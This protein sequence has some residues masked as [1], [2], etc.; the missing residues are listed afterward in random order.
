MNIIWLTKLTDSDSFRITQIMMSEALHKQGNEVT[1][2]LARDFSEKKD[3]QKG[4]LYL[5]T[6]NA[7]VLSGIVYGMI[8]FWYFPF[9]A[10]KKKADIVIVGGD[11]IWSPFLFSLKLWGIPV[12]FDIRSL[13]TDTER[14]LVRD[15]SFYLSR[16]LVDGLTTITPELAEIL[17]KQYHLQAKK[18][19]VWSSGFSKNQFKGIEPKQNDFDRSD[20]FILLHHGT[21]T[22]TRGIEEVIHS[23][24][25]IDETERKKIK[26]IIVGIPGNKIEELQKLCQE[27]KITEYVEILPRVD[28]HMIPS[29]I[30]GCDVGI[31]PLPPNNVWWRVSVPL[32]T[33]EY[34]AMGKPIIATKIPFHQKIFE[35]ANCGVLLETNDPQDI[36]N[37]ISFLYHHSDQLKDMGN[38]GKEIVERYYSWESKAFELNNFLK[39]ILAGKDHEIRTS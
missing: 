10:K 18:I 19:M 29:Y 4:I 39:T 1:L 33:L 12:I 28:I 8:I 26:L 22:P 34:L 23:I 9:L 2:T 16:Y 5:P 14:S 36:A 38:R 15:I 7:K 6:I 20:Q 31:I 11:T 13:E 37:A 3:P 25:K 35:L 32:K 27:L 24:A 17:K 30:Q 21:Y